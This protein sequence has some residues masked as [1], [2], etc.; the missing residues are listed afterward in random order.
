MN[1]IALKRSCCRSSATSALG[2]PQSPPTCQRPL[3]LAC[4]GADRTPAVRGRQ[5]PTGN[6]HEITA[7]LEASPVSAPVEATPALLAG[8]GDDVAFPQQRRPQSFRLR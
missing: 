2:N 6:F 7:S 3:A 5:E 4:R 1:T 8:E